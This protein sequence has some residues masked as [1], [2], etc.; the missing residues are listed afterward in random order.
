MTAIEFTY[1]KEDFDTTAP[2]E[3][4]CNIEDPFQQGIAERKL[5]EYAK[6]VGFSSFRA[7]LKAV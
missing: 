3:H 5:T 4:I 7:A 6:T 2:Y 1:S